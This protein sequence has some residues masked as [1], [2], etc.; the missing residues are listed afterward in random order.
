MTV[1]AYDILSNHQMARSH[2]YCRSFRGFVTSNVILLTFPGWWV[3]VTRT[4]RL[5]KV[6]VKKVT[7][8]ESPDDFVW[9]PPCIIN[10]WINPPGKTVR[11]FEER[12]VCL[13]NA[14]LMDP[15][16]LKSIQNWRATQKVG[17]KVLRLTASWCSTPTSLRPFAP[18]FIRKMAI[19]CSFA[20]H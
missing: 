7:A 17:P 6:G 3:Y 4:Q 8:A 5:T 18:H 14:W 9:F 13:D 1:D 16:S 20:H 11:F 10:F 12:F 19:F 15:W 2:N